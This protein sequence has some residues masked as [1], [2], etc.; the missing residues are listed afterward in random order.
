MEVARRFWHAVFGGETK[1]VAQA[2]ERIRKDRAAAER[3]AM[4]AD[5]VVPRLHS[6]VVHEN[7]IAKA[8]EEFWTGRKHT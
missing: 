2:E 5:L 8:I 6:R 3:D 4:R 7:H 1:E